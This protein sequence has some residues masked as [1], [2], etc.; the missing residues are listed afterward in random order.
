MFTNT[1]HCQVKLP[2]FFTNC[3]VLNIFTQ[4]LHRLAA[5]IKAG[6][7]ESNTLKTFSMELEYTGAFLAE[8]I[9]TSISRPLE[10]LKMIG[11]QF[12]E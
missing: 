7:S 1:E 8:C 10:E 11:F 9:L 3:L 4:S 6:L 5:A 2:T 12:R